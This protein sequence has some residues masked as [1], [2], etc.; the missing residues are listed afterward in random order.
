MKGERGGEIVGCKCISYLLEK[1]RVVRQTLGERNFHVFYM[2]LVG[3]ESSLVADFKLKKPSAFNFLN[4]SD[5]MEISGR[6]DKEE[7]E[8]LLEAFRHVGF[9]QSHQKQILQC[10]AGILHLGNVQFSDVLQTGE[11]VNPISGLKET[12]GKEDESTRG[13]VTRSTQK[14]LLLAARMLEMMDLS[15]V[16]SDIGASNLEH[17]LC[18]VV[19]RGAANTATGMAEVVQMPVSALQAANNRDALAK[20]CYDKLFDKIVTQVNRSLF[21]GRDEGWNIGVLGKRPFFFVLFSNK[22]RN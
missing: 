14:D 13:A 19:V 10:L 6:S 1:S 22:E 4:Q 9:A 3:A 7:F 8:M 18:Y 5:F 12:K 2:L 16:S 21:K 11:V 17:A 20:A 15:D